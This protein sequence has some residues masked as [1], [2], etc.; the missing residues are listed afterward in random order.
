MKVA[1]LFSGAGGLDLGFKNAGFTIPWAN[2]KNR[3][4]W[5]T[6]EHNFPDTELDRRD[7]RHVSSDDIPDAIDG[8]VGG[9]PCQSWSEAGAR[10]GIE[11][12][13]GQLFFDYIRILREKQPKFFLA[14]NVQGLLFKRNEGALNSIM[15]AFTE[16][17]YTVSYKLLNT[18]DFNVPQDRKRVIFIGFRNDLSIQFKFPKPEDNKLVL[19]D[20]IRDL[21]HSAMPAQGKNHTNGQ[22]LIVANHEYMTGGFSPIYMS[23]NRVRTWDEPS[24]T[25]QASGRHA[26][27][28]PQ[29]NRMIKAGKDKFIFDEQSPAPYRRLS[30]REAAR[31]QTFPDDFKFVYKRIDDGY[32][33]VGNAVPV[34][35]AEA[36]AT[37]IASYLDLDNTLNRIDTSQKAMLTESNMMG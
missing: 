12:T 30:I 32:K 19:R 9:P 29:A 37:Q 2:E 8:I 34:K 5:A 15:N 25:I 17:G 11:D 24:F 28:H 20:C 4:I 36:I 16:S 26:P 14:E 3:A 13:R 27:I 31:V 7:I 33:M 6:F 23:R 18:V 21:Q 10:R 22:N 35:F 1:S